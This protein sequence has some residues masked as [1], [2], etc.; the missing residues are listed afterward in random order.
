M[1]P[2]SIL[3]F[4]H[5]EVVEEVSLARHWAARLLLLVLERSFLTLWIVATGEMKSTLLY[6]LKL[7][8][9]TGR[10]ALRQ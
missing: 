10:D 7:L 9:T 6:L 5:N 2:K 3:I 4:R 1:S 8:T